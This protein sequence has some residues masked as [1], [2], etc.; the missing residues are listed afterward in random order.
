MKDLGKKWREDRQTLWDKLCDPTQQKE[1]NYQQKPNKVDEAKWQTF[2]DH[3]MSKYMKKISAINKANRAK[4]KIYHTSGSKSILAKGK[5][6]EDEWGRP[7]TRG[8]LFRETHQRTGRSG[9]DKYPNEETRE[10]VVFGSSSQGSASQ[11]S[12]YTDPGLRLF[13]DGVLSVLNQIVSSSQLPPDVM[14]AVNRLTQTFGGVQSS[15]HSHGDPPGGA[16]RSSRGDDQQSGEARIPETASSP[17][18][19]VTRI[20]PSAAGS[21]NKSVG[22]SNSSTRPAPTDD[23]VLSS[24]SSD[25]DSDSDSE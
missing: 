8:E 18:V 21:G 16:P 9:P 24:T 5:E 15:Q 10:A 1:H 19:D 25:S 7:P 12:I 23:N 13:T 3:R 4:Q 2:V 14:A 20:S 22:A 11:S 17:L 6:L